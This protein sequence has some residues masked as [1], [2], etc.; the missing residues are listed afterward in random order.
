MN[1]LKLNENEN[2][3]YYKLEINNNCY[4]VKQLKRKN[5]IL[6]KMLQNEVDNLNKLK[7]LNVPTIIY[8]NVEEG[9]IIY[10]Y[11]QGDNLQK[12][13]LSNIKEITNIVFKILDGISLIH[14]QGIIHCDIK[15]S[16]IILSDDKVYIIDFGI[17]CTNEKNEFSGYG[18]ISYCSPEQIKRKKITIQ[19]DIYSLG[20][21]MY[22][23]YTRKLPFTFGKY[24]AKK[25]MK[26][27]F[28]MKLLPPSS[29]NKELP[30]TLDNIIEKCLKIDPNERFS[31]IDELKNTLRRQL[32]N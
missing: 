3:T 15:K 14:M 21:L 29:I 31:S 10:K 30:K 22:E 25:I 7:G 19:S 18:S 1:Y 4:F 8:Y 27:H 11:I 2:Y 16:N 32:N 5:S 12:I 24:D 28:E 17:S 26:N 13:N 9:Y 20:V 23:L 6:I